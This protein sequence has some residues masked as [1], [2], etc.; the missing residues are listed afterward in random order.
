MHQAQTRSA[1]CN[2]TS[3]PVGEDESGI[4]RGIYRALHE[5]QRLQAA[6][7]GSLPIATDVDVTLSVADER[8]V[9]LAKRSQPRKD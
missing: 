3:D 5:L 6:R 2:F 8:S 9:A 1:W 7:S 4:E